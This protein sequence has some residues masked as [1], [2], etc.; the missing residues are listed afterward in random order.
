MRTTLLIAVLAAGCVDGLDESTTS[1]EQE[2]KCDPL[3][4]STN[5]DQVPRPGTEVWEA[6]LF[7]LADS[8]GVSLMTRGPSTK[9]QGRRHAVI[10]DV[11]DRMW[12]LNV[13]GGK[14]TGTPVSGTGRLSGRGLVG[15]SFQFQRNGVALYGVS[16]DAV[17]TLTMQIPENTTDTIEVYTMSWYSVGT[18]APLAVCPAGAG[19]GANQ[20]VVFEGDRFNPTSLTVSPQ[21]DTSWFNLACGNSVLAKL[22]MLRKTSSNG[23]ATWQG[24]QAAFKMLTADYCGHGVSFT[25]LGTGITWAD[26][27]RTVLY[28]NTGVPNPTR[29]EARWNENGATCISG[30]RLEGYP[31]GLHIMDLVREECGINTFPAACFDTRFTTPPLDDFADSLIISALP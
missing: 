21:L 31:G 28:P 23:T 15:A 24:R 5:S 9:W 1:I 29:I 17:N 7:G 30:A 20:T 11:N 2:N 10:F 6:N 19:L 27:E 16:I 25:N 13:S 22:R 18:G 12:D 4:C 3:L 26:R 8:K 14:I